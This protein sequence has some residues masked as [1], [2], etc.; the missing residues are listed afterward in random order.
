L[1][2]RDLRTRTRWSGPSLARPP[3]ARAASGLQTLDTQT[4]DAQRAHAGAAIPAAG[5]RGD[6]AAALFAVLTDAR[7]VSV[8]N[9]PAGSGKTR[10]LTEAGR[11]WAAGPGRRRGRVIGVTPSQSSRNTLAAGVAECYNTAQFLG[12][13]PGQ[14]GAR[15]AVEL[16]PGDLVLMDEASM[17]SSPDLADTISHAAASGAKVILAGDTAQLQA[18]ENGGGMSLLAGVLGYVQLAEPV[19]FR[20]AWERTASLRLRDGDVSVLAD[21]DQHGRIKSGDPEDMVDA[22]AS[23]YAALTLEGKDTL[24]MAADHARRQEMSLGV[25][26]Q[27][28]SAPRLITVRNVDHARVQVDVSPLQPAQFAAA[29]PR[30]S[31]QPE[32]HGEQVQLSPASCGRH[33]ARSQSW[34]MSP[35]RLRCE[36]VPRGWPERRPAVPAGR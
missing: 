18:V 10:V 9:A 15:G 11:M 8:I 3:G 29:G 25:L 36:I 21:Y 6:Q 1:S 26:A 32:V 35:R 28:L 4:D 22:A 13:L 31:G 14:R 34:P 12:H 27:L 33:P 30:N 24:L 19:R 16:R 2:C 5:L 20:A 23:A 17:V 7:C